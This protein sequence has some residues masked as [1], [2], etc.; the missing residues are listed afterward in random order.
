MIVRDREI[1]TNG[2]EADQIHAANL[3]L[4]ETFAG[5]ILNLAIKLVDA[6]HRVGEPT[7]YLQHIIQ[8]QIHRETNASY[9]CHGKQWDGGSQPSFIYK[10]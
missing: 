8:I 10:R 6:I 4:M 3:I 5:F 2:S 1:E 9:C 7:N